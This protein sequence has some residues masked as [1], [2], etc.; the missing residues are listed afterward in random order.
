[1]LALR[2]SVPGEE[3][4]SLSSQ[5]ARRVLELPEVEKARTIS[6]YLHIG[7]EVR[8]RAIVD[9]CLAR[10]KRVVVPVT[11]KSSRRLIFSELHYPDREL[12]LGTFGIPEP[13]HE[14]LR[15]VPLDEAEVVLI[16]GIAWDLRGY[17]IGYGGGFYDRSINALRTPL[18]KVG[19]VY[20]FQ[21]IR[22]IPVTRYDRPVDIMVT[23]HRVITAS[24]KQSNRTS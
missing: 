18:K 11:N 8:T 10:G 4:D 24:A 9:W 5:I 14:F 22:K 6:T 2:N 13:K 21:I 19:L 17:R 12:E 1:M 16:P 23:E 3:L 7:S 15:P 20:E